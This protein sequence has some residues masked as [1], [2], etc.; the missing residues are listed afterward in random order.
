VIV[1]LAEGSLIGIGYVVAEVPNPLLFTVL[2]AAFAMVPF[3]AWA[4]FTVAALLLLVNDGSPSAA[5]AVFAWGAVVMLVGDQFVWPALVGGAARLPF[6]LALIGIFGGLQTFGLIGLFL[7]PV[8]MAAL[9]T[10]WREWLVNVKDHP[11]PPA[12][13]G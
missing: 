5:V 13:V 10:V 2:T 7:G 6:I 8:I 1:A 4:A 12:G 9:L 11:D 3:G